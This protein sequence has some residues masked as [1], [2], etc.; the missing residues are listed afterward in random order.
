MRLIGCLVMKLN[1]FTG[2]KL[3][4]SGP[5]DKTSDDFEFGSA[6]I[7]IMMSD[8][9]MFSLAQKYVRVTQTSA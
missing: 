6:D 4:F 3:S 8:D 2:L 9:L 1:A 5:S 7:C